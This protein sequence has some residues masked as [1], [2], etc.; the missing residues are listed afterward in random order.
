MGIEK[1]L[2][3]FLFAV[4]ISI[5]PGPNNIM[6]AATGVNVGIHRG[7]PHFLG[8]VLGFAVLMGSVAMGI[9]SIVT[10]WPTAF[11]VLKVAS[12]AAL[13]WLSLKI[14]T[15]PPSPGKAG[16]KRPI[17]FIEAAA[18]QWINPKAWIFTVSATSLYI[19][20]DDIGTIPQAIVLTLVS[21]V[22]T[23]ISAGSWLVLGALIQNL[24]NTPHR[25]R[26][27][28]VTMGV[29]LAGSAVFL[30]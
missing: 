27:F 12:V 28:N 6:L 9:G 21:M 2:G 23:V 15:A 5:T 29:L 22:A 10:Q 26:V 17:S 24:L 18:F 8:V 3:F 25:L 16:R 1:L 13:L 4:F 11:N 7:L 19:G 14:A 30:I 20:G